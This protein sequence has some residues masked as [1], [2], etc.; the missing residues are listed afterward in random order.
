MKDTFKTIRV[1]S[2]GQYKEKGSKFLGFGY[3]VN[4]ETEIKNILEATKKKY[5][6]AR[7]HCYAHQIGIGNNTIYR[8]ND[9]REPSG[10]AGKPI[11]GQIL[12]NNLTNILIVVVRYFGGKLLG[13][14]GLINAY[15]NAAEDVIKNSEIIEKIIEKEVILNFPYS[16]INLI[17][18]I[19]KDEN[20]T[21]LE[22][23]YD[24]DCEIKLGIRSS[25][26]DRIIKK[27]NSIENINIIFN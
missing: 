20:L 16:S 23:Q 3:P 4:N 7:H 10:T 17:M 26:F 6:D 25:K 5:H 11:Y 8:F 9:D 18:T 12:S 2:E 22:N 1:N 27:L 19:I 13:V 14:S 24:N 15:R 21:I